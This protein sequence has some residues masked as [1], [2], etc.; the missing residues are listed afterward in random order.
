MTVSFLESGAAGDDRLV[1][2]FDA[3]IVLG[4]VSMPGGKQGRVASIPLFQ[5]G[6]LINPSY[7]K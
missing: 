4:V 3:A 6:I 1:K 7:V 5:Q 2:R